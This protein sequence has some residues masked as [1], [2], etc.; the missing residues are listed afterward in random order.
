MKFHITS[1]GK[2]VPTLGVSPGREAKSS[3][4]L[5]G[6]VD[7]SNWK[8]WSDAFHGFSRLAVSLIAGSASTGTKAANK[9]NDRSYQHDSSN[10]SQ[11]HFPRGEWLWVQCP[12]AAVR[13]TVQGP[14]RWRFELSLRTVERA[15]EIIACI[16]G[17]HLGHR[18]TLDR[19][20]ETSHS[21]IIGASRVPHH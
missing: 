21:R 17:V 20:E 1:S 9:Q 4:M 12:K 3:I 7:V 18:R 2:P 6:S 15:D 8:N 5:E 14:P 13:S 11:R 10:H 19:G 16:S